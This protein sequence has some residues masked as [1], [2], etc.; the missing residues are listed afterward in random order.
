MLLQP[1]RETVFLLDVLLASKSWR[2]FQPTCSRHK[3]AQG[4]VMRG[5]FLASNATVT[6]R[7]FVGTGRSPTDRYFDVDSPRFAC[8]CWRFPEICRNGLFPSVIHSSAQRR[9]KFE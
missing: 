2:G 3:L 5:Q 4:L 9:L 7:T 1:H 6:A 8:A